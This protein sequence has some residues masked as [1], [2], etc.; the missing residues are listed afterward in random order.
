MYKW[1]AD[2][3][4]DQT[5]GVDIYA[6]DN[7]DF[8]LDNTYS[9]YI[10]L[11]DRSG[12]MRGDRIGKAKNSLIY[13]LRSLPINSRFNV[14]SFGSNFESMFP[15]PIEYTDQNLNLAENKINK[16]RANMGG[17]VILSALNHVFTRPKPA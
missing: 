17:T 13:F 3:G 4:I 2:K 12:S 8:L 16:F 1:Y 9:E 5:Q 14:V 7:E 15:T 6:E 10:F 11:L